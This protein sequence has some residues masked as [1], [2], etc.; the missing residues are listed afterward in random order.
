M[1]LFVLRRFVQPAGV[2]TVTPLPPRTARVA[3]IRSFWMTPAGM[4][5]TTLFAPAPVLLVA[6]P[7]R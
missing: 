1:P 3:T 6:T 5:R 7:L 4:F 2:A